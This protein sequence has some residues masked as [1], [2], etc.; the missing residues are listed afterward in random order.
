MQQN[1]I[2]QRSIAYMSQ[3]ECQ[4][5]NALLK[6]VSITNKKLL[7]YHEYYSNTIKTLENKIQTL[8]QKANNSKIIINNKYDNVFSYNNTYSSNSDNSSDNTSTIDKES[9]IYKID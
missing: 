5:I 3:Y 7:K 2:L 1:N 6:T 9:Y 8:T 4:M